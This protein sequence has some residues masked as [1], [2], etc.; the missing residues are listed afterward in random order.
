MFHCATIPTFSGNYN[1]RPFRAAIA[2][3]G[4][5]ST[6]ILEALWKTK[7][8]KIKLDAVGACMLICLLTRVD[9]TSRKFH[10]IIVIRHSYKKVWCSVTAHNLATLSWSA[11][12]LTYSGYSNF[13]QE[14]MTFAE[15][16]TKT[17]RIF[18]NFYQDQPYD[19]GLKCIVF[20]TLFLFSLHV[21]YSFS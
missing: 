15:I 17:K 8:S 20:F 14:P 16:F 6:L 21:F 3:F 1:V 7:S 13:W 12:I 19:F 18:S 9:P 11:C 5:C 10:L 4:E 2:Y